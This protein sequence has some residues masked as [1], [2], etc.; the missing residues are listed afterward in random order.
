MNYTV[1]DQTFVILSTEGNK[2]VAAELE[3]QVA[4]EIDRF[5]TADAW[6]V[7]VR[8]RLE[9]VPEDEAD[10]LDIPPETSWVPTMKYDVVRV[11]PDVITGRRFLLRRPEG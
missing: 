5:R 7:L 11:R 2:L 3:E 1:H 6:S 9:R 8:G 10:R 4:L